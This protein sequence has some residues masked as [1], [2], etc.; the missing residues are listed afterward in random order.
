MQGLDR[1]G[2]DDLNVFHGSTS[3][4]EFP[5]GFDMTVATRDISHP[6]L[7]N[8]PLIQDMMSST[9]EKYDSRESVNFEALFNELA[10]LDDA[11]NPDY[12]ALFMQNLGLA[13]NVD[14]NDAFSSEFGF[15]PLFSAYM[16]PGSGT[17]ATDQT[18]GFTT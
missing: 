9:L 5:T 10:S 8:S 7:N 4:A 1:R 18:Q 13:P 11:E 3:N 12:Q 15:D 16:H 17:T 14:L 6:D 2:D